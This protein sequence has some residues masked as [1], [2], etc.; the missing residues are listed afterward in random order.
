VIAASDSLDQSD[1]TLLGV[2]R[3]H[4]MAL[5]LV[6]V[7]ILLTV[8]P[9]QRWFH[10]T[11][12][13]QLQSLIDEPYGW[14]FADSAPTTHESKLVLRRTVPFMAHGL[15]LPAIKTNWINVYFALILYLSAIT[16][17]R[18]HLGEKEALA[19]VIAI[20]MTF[21]GKHV[22]TDMECYYDAVAMGFLFA[23]FASRRTLIIGACVFLSGWTDERGLVASSFVALYWAWP[24]MQSGTTRERLVAT[25]R[26]PQVIAIVVAWILFFVSRA[27][28]GPA[29]GWDATPVTARLLQAMPVAALTAWSSIEGFWLLVVLVIPWLWHQ[30]ARLFAVGLVVG[31]TCSLG[32]AMIV[33]D[34]SRSAGYLIAC[35]PVLIAIFQKAET[36]PTRKVWLR[37]VL[38][39]GILSPTIFI[40]A[41]NSVR[42]AAEELAPLTWSSWFE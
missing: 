25:F 42:L 26:S 2:G 39:V 14:P 16:V 38:I 1:G 34:H 10:M 24:H 36:G 9:N 4:L 22:T 5:L 28:A 32:G 7:T 31:I 6:T 30:G 13:E 27:A 41:P 8:P 18:R 33:L 19:M 3:P 15:G 37:A 21:G 12:S 20:S 40:Q 17:L 35:I 23:A 29:F 11:H